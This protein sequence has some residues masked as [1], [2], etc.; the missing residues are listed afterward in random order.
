MDPTNTVVKANFNITVE[1]QDRVIRP[2]VHRYLDLLLTSLR[3]VMRNVDFA[4][5]CNSNPQVYIQNMPL[6]G[7]Q[8]VSIGGNHQLSL[9]KRLL[10]I[11]L[12]ELSGAWRQPDT[13]GTLSADTLQAG[14]VL[15]PPYHSHHAET[16][17]TNQPNCK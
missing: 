8:K 7:H 11:G 17:Y 16:Y 12:G 13:Q 1:I 3:S 6:T 4:S 15:P 5:V 14:S 10:T 9:N 2:V